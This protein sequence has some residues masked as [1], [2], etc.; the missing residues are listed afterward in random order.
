MPKIN[1]LWA[2]VPFVVTSRDGTKFETTVSGRMRWAL[3][4]LVKAGATGCTALETPALRWAA[5]VHFLRRRHIEIETVE[6]PHGGPF[7]G[8]HARYILR[9]GVVRVELAGG[10][11]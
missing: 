8:T 2:N 9:S 1:P 4:R 3:E 11:T 5:Y 6:E 7:P 10:L